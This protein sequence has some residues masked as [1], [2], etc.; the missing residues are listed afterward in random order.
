MKHPEKDYNKSQF[1][2]YTWIDR[3]NIQKVYIFRNLVRS[4]RKWHLY[5][6][7]FIEADETAVSFKSLYEI[8]LYSLRQRSTE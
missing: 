4:H 2:A 8:L 5:V 1:A 3:K 7:D 6:F